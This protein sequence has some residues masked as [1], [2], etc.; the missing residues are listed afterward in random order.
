MKINYNISTIRKALDSIEKSNPEKQSLS[1]FELEQI[2]KKLSNPLIY[3]IEDIIKLLSDY[4]EDNDDE[5]IFLH[6]ETEICGIIKVKKLAM[7]HW[8]RKGYIQYTMFNGN[9]RT[10]RYKPI[11]LLEDLRNVRDKNIS[12]DTLY[13]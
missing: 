9:N 12:I 4:I 11:T 3:N 10:I 1:F 2:T 13:I 8:R 5:A 7:H 6:S